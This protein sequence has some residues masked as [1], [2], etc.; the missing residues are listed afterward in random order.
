MASSYKDDLRYTP[1][2][3]YETLPI[4]TQ[5]DSKE[6]LEERGRTYYDHRAALMIAH[7]A[8]ADEVCALVDRG[9]VCGTAPWKT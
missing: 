4:P 9:C 1:S 6:L 5:V 7:K 8:R 2:D 3:C